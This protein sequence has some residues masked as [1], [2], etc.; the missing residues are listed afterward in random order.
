MDPPPRITRLTRVERQI[1]SLKPE[2]N[3]K[4]LGGTRT[5]NVLHVLQ[6]Q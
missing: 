1:C 5:E 6:E 3:C 4:E 2:R